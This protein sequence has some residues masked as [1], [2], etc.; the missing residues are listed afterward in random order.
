M[1]KYPL[2]GTPRYPSYR[3]EPFLCTRKASDW[4][5][6]ARGALD[7]APGSPVVPGGCSAARHGER[8]A[9]ALSP[10]ARSGRPPRQARPAGT[11]S[12]LH[13]VPG[14]GWALGA[15]AAGTRPRSESHYKPTREPLPASVTTMWEKPLGSAGQRLSA[16]V[17]PPAKPG[18]RC[19]RLS[20]V[21]PCDGGCEAL[22]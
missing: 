8:S 20:S 5:Q 2:L 11:G 14:S 18:Y 22:E 15:A 17:S 1:S 9:Q 16:K 3:H 19:S 21:P 12:T 13:A 10:A 4:C 7:P 6:L